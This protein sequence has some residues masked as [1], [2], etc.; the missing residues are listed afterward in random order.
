MGRPEKNMKDVIEFS[1]TIRKA[2]EK[3]K[4]NH[5]DFATFLGYSRETYLK[6]YNG[7]SLPGEARKKEV[8]KKLEMILS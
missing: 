2:K 8:L 6:W 3:V 1:K 5:H 4:M 7:K